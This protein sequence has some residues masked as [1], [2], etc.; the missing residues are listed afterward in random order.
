MIRA[1]EF[2]QFVACP[3]YYFQVQAMKELFTTE[4]LTN[5][6]AELGTK[7]HALIEE[8]ILENRLEDSEYITSK[9]EDLNLGKYRVPATKYIGE[10]KKLLFGRQYLVEHTFAH[11]DLTGTADIMIIEHDSI[12]FIDHKTTRKDKGVEYW[13]HNIQPM[14]YAEFARRWFKQTFDREVQTVYF[15]IGLVFFNRL[16][17]FVYTDL[18]LE[19]N[20]KK[21]EYLYSEYIT[22][23]GKTIHHRALNEDC[24]YCPLAKE[25][26]LNIAASNSFALSHQ[27]MFREP[28]EKI[29]YLRNLIDQ[30]N[31][32]FHQLT[33]DNLE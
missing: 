25:C 24:P 20:R 8:L 13:K 26:S 28:T 33:G 11:T 10:I 32:Q 4:E 1:T 30:L 15:T 5:K 12:H 23:Q 7:Y 19:R 21:I 29:V 27:F 2:R 22:E 3:E 6:Y 9:I 17:N 14:V 16:I 31:L 18:E